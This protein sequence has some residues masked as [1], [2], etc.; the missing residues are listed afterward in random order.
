MT[1]TKSQEDPVE[2]KTDGSE[3]GN[4]DALISDEKEEDLVEAFKA[5]GDDGEGGKAEWEPTDDEDDVEG[6]EEQGGLGIMRC[7]S[8]RLG[9][10]PKFSAVTNTCGTTPN[11]LSGAPTRGS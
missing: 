4:D 5:P 6:D 11:N 9:G 7:P 10:R 3:S 8:S 1:E 2:G